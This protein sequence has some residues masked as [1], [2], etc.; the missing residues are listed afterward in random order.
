MALK[1]KEII[2]SRELYVTP[3]QNCALRI[4]RSN[5]AEA[6]VDPLGWNLQQYTSPS[7]PESS[8]IGAWR[9][10]HLGGP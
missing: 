7:C 10:E 3:V 8:M 5:P 4:S 2:I 6:R 9:E 1:I